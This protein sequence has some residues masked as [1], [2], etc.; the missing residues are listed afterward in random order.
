MQ[1]RWW[2][3]PDGFP[4]VVAPG[5]RLVEPAGLFQV[6]IEES[7]WRTEGTPCE[8]NSSYQG[9]ILLALRVTQQGTS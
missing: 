2:A 8:G 6:D 1:G 4:E 9:V 7:G 5:L 3:G